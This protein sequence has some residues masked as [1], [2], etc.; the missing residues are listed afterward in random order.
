METVSE[1]L[2]LFVDFVEVVV[3]VAERD[4]LQTVLVHFLVF[5]CF[6]LLPLINHRL[7]QFLAGAGEDGVLSNGVFKSFELRFNLLTLRL[8][9]IEFG[10]E[11][12]R[13]LIVTVLC[14]FQI[15]SHLMHIS[16]CV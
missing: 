8:F 16:E 13:H 9:L 11:F 1:L 15:E 3:S 4:I 6:V 7:L 12:R 5:E 14:F 2:F 10:L